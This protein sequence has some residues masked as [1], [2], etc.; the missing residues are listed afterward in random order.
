MSEKTPIA[1]IASVLRE[2]GWY[3]AKFHLRV[4]ET[5]NSVDVAL[6]SQD[7]MTVYARLSADQHFL[8]DQPLRINL[9]FPSFSG[10]AKEAEDYLLA[11]TQV[12]VIA[13]RLEQHFT[14]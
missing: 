5:E 6:M 11:Q 4:D 14:V 12:V 13:K 8:R 7:K 3:E 1:K 10:P 2:L 9:S